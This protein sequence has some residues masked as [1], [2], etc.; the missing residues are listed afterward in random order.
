MGCWI[1]PLTLEIKHYI[2]G[3]VARK[4]LAESNKYLS[5]SH[6][7]LKLDNPINLLLDNN[8]SSLIQAWDR[9]EWW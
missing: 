7:N 3:K 4:T 9:Q 5:I 6:K 2:V 8:P 1:W